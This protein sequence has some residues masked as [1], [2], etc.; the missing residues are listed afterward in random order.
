MRSRPQHRAHSRWQTVNCRSSQTMAFAQWRAAIHCAHHRPASPSRLHAM[1]MCTS[2]TIKPV[3]RKAVGGAWAGRIGAAEKRRVS[4][5]AHS[6][7]RDLTRRVCP[8]AANEV[9]VASYATG[10][11]TRAS[12]GTRS[13]AKGKPSE[14]RPGPTH[15]LACAD[16]GVRQRSPLTLALSQR[17]KVLSARAARSEKSLICPS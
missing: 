14:P 13:A 12:Q 2:S 6:A 1:A 10:P 8:S 17:S 7:L 16:L 15:R 11:G 5:R 4:G 3:A 9:S